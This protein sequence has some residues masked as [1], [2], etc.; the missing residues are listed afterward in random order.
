MR[1]L[2]SSQVL[3]SL[4]AFAFIFI[5]D[6]RYLTGMSYLA[7]LSLL[8]LLYG[9]K[10]RRVMFLFPITLGFSYVP[11]SFLYPI[12][13]YSIVKMAVIWPLLFAL[14]STLSYPESK[15]LEKRA[16]IVAFVSSI[17]GIMAIEGAL[18]ISAPVKDPIILAVLLIAAGISMV[19]MVVDKG[20]TSFR[21]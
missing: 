14:Y 10:E 20:F 3:L 4:F 15:D 1:N 9:F 6:L 13:I 21:R 19:Y 12:D 17:L 11:V 2:R 5:E 7:L 16:F 18:S 8:F